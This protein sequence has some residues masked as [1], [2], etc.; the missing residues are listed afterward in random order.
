MAILD[1]EREYLDMAEAMSGN[2]INASGGDGA[3]VNPLQLRDVPEAFDDMTEAQ[4]I[5]AAQKPDFQGALSLHIPFLRKW[6]RMYIPDLNQIET[7]VLETA[8]Y[9]V[10]RRKGITEASD[11]RKMSNDEFPIMSDVYDVLT[12][13]LSTHVIG[14]RPAEDD[15]V[16]KS[17]LAYMDPLVY[18]SD[19][20]MF[21]GITTVNL[22]RQ[23]NVFNV[24]KLLEAPSNTKNAQFFN[25]VSFLW[26]W[27]SSDRH[28]RTILM[29]DEGH[30]FISAESTV[31]FEFLATAMRRVRKYEAA[32]ILS[33]QQIADFLSRGANFDTAQLEVMLTSTGINCFMRSKATDINYLNHLFG[34]S[35][36]EE[37]F[38]QRAER[39]ECLLLAG[40]SRST[41]KVEVEKNMLKLIQKSGG[42]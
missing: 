9:E 42:N 11:P 7:A 26:L 5:A 13:A 19:R 22:D 17:L 33:T 37:Q 8:L 40:N 34:T 29:V 12:E 41:I 25:L 35:A 14:T 3:R 6:F 28:Q 16:L 38:V 21:N 32:I 30:L 27:M 31:T 10:Y 2:V 20:F 4:Q 15:R 23:F 18:G 36:V 1:A 24:N 39:G